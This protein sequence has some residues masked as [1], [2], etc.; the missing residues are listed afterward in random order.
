MELC[1]TQMV[2]RSKDHLVMGHQ[3]GPIKLLYPMELN[4]LFVQF[5]YE[6]SVGI[7]LLVMRM[8]KMK[9]KTKMKEI[10]E[11][12]MILLP[13]HLILKFL[14]NFPMLK[15]KHQPR[16]LMW[17]TLWWMREDLIS[18]QLNPWTKK[19]LR[20]F[21]TEFWTIQRNFWWKFYLEFLKKIFN[22]F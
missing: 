3:L 6:V 1:V 18:L 13:K 22:G 5:Q 9:M 7:M 17:W 11:D 4:K 8:K 2:E 19:L 12:K 10:K 14:M 21:P 20:N 15:L 16:T